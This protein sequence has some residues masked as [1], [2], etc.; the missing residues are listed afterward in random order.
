MRHFRSATLIKRAVSPWT[1]AGK[2]DAKAAKLLKGEVDALLDHSV[3]PGV[4]TRDKESQRLA[5]EHY[6]FN[7][8]RMIDM[9]ESVGA[10][11]LLITPSDNLRD[12]SPFKS[13]FSQTLSVEKQKEWK[14]YYDQARQAYAQKNAPLALQSVAKAEKIDPLPA[15]L[16][17]VKG[18][19]FEA[20]GKFDEAKTAY[21]RA[22]DEDVCPLRALSPVQGI[23]QEVASTRRVPLV[24]FV[25]MQNS[26]S[27]NG[28][29]GSDVFLDHVHPTIESHRKLALEILRQMESENWITVSWDQEI[30]TQV[31]QS[32][33]ANINKEEHALAMMN[34]AKVLG[35]AGKRQEAYLA[36][37][38]SIELNPDS[39][40]G[41]F[42]AGLA[43]FLAGKPDD[44]ILHY[45]QALQI[46]PTHADTHCNL[47]AMLEDQ[48]DI[49][50]AIQ[51]FKEALSHGDSS[52]R[53]RN[54]NN[55]DAAMKKLHQGDASRQSK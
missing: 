54:Q 52:S 47:G 48:G 1:T 25:S 46:D 45:R 5:L 13:D 49:Q 50:Q 35:W 16:H 33:L 7:L 8:N 24:D 36:S 38:K 23:L 18:R 2:E 55:L 32:V 34:L 10:K 9:A 4:Y 53:E 22:R 29:P 15:S 14:N 31:T 12:L 51:H 11:V 17:F 28:I 39:A 20:I 27:R 26:L 43:A 21:E 40:N 44:A 3:G 37:Q 42:Q 41:Q 19:I 6:R 30:I